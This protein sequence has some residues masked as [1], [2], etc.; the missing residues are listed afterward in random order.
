MA[1]DILIKSELRACYV[2]DKKALFHGWF[3][4]SEIVAPSVMVGGHNG[5]VLNYVCG[6]VEYINGKTDLVE[7]TKIRFA[8]GGEFGDRCFVPKEVLDHE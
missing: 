4:F 6:L 3:P 2:E 1:R 5:G 7:P 8:D